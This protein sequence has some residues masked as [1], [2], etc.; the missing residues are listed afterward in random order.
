MSPFDFMMPTPIQSS[1]SGM[2]FFSVKT[3]SNFQVRIKNLQVHLGSVRIR[4]AHLLSDIA[5]CLEHWRHT[6]TPSVPEN[7]RSEWHR[8]RWVSLC[9][10]PLLDACPF[11]PMV[12]AYG[13]RANWFQNRLK[14]KIRKIKLICMTIPSKND[15]CNIYI[16]WLSMYTHIPS[17]YQE[18]LV[19]LSMSHTQAYILLQANSRAHQ[20]SA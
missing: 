7:L 16:S 9:P 8:P 13:I 20:S 4:A 2:N 11:G 3:D 19:W 15:F 18:R 14:K 6:C 1:M 5:L 17:F 10:T 12:R